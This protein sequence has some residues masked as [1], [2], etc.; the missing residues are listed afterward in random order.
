MHQIEKLSLPIT[1]I[2]CGFRRVKLLIL[3]F[4]MRLLSVGFGRFRTCPQGLRPSS[5]CGRWLCT[6]PWPFGGRSGAIDDTAST[7]P[8]Q[9]TVH[10]YVGPF[11]SIIV[12]FDFLN[13]TSPSLCGYSYDEMFYK[14]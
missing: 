6:R 9:S 1:A 2:F 7:S 3:Y 8:S 13:L 14:F 10:L 4:R 5:F 12:S 11:Y